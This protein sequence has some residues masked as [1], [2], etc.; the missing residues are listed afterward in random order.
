MIC[1]ILSR[2][3]AKIGKLFILHHHHQRQSLAI[4]DEGVVDLEF[5]FGRWTHF[6][7]YY[8]FL[9]QQNIFLYGRTILYLCDILICIFVYRLSMFLDDIVE[10]ALTDIQMLL[11]AIYINKL[12]GCNKEQ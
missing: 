9:I 3:I 8:C 11:I 4:I 1:K 6:Y 10:Q 12:C 7:I 5:A 2:S